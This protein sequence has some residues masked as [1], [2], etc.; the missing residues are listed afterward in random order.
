MSTFKSRESGSVGT[1]GGSE[2]ANGGLAFMP[3]CAAAESTCGDPPEKEDT[4][5][6]PV[7]DEEAEGSRSGSV[8]AL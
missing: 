2:G 1:T 6:T 8:K 7:W 5:Q 3:S 4:S